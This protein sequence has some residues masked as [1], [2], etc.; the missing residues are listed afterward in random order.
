MSSVY[1][2]IPNHFVDKYGNPGEEE[3]NT[4]G[5]L[6]VKGD[7]YKYVTDGLIV[8][9]ADL[10]KKTHLSTYAGYSLSD[11][12][13][14]SEGTIGYGS[15]GFYKLSNRYFDSTY[16]Q[17]KYMFSYNMFLGRESNF[18]KTYSYVSDD[19]FNHV[20]NFLLSDN[21]NFYV[22]SENFLKY[23]QE[24][25]CNHYGDT[26]GL[27]KGN[28]DKFD[29]LEDES[30]YVTV[31]DASL[32][33]EFEK[34][35]EKTFWNKLF[36]TG[37]DFDY[38]DIRPLIEISSSDVSDSKTV[39]AI[40]DNLFI[41][42]DDV[43][44]LQTFYDK[45]GSDNHI[46]LMRFDVNPYYA[47]DVTVTTN[48]LDPSDSDCHYDGVYFEK[49]VYHDFDIIEFRFKNSEGEVVKVPVSCNP[50]NIVGGVVGPSVKDP[51]NPNKDVNGDGDDSMDWLSK[52][53]KWFKDLKAG[54]K[55]LAVVMF[56]VI[57][58]AT[59][60]LISKI[61][62]VSINAIF[63]GVGWCIALPFRLIGKGASA[64]KA[65]ITRKR[66]AKQK[67][68]DKNKKE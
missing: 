6:S 2:S 49:V 14:Y 23:Y 28:A 59:I 32:N 43:K 18:I 10:Y 26:G 39:G 53:I 3:Y 7:Y 52:L 16:D 38:E 34:K 44:P 62:K 47:T 68:K 50:I 5:L 55:I 42:Y 13:S 20:C 29:R 15:V 30:L 41:M 45:Y 48:P 66:K 65:A 22:S 11:Y 31:T 36:G 61:T 25:G 60:A 63:K 40:A 4:S 67:E 51:N 24:N 46:Y 56:F 19:C 57:I 37:S 8:N 58:F 1:F 33:Q 35:Y 27:W 12:P 9:D 64:A 54:Y 17:W 21:D